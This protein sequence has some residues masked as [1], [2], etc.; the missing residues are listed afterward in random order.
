[1]ASSSTRRRGLGGSCRVLLR[2]QGMTGVGRPPPRLAHLRL[3]V[4]LAPHHASAGANRLHRRPRGSGAEGAP[5][6]CTRRATADSG[7]TGAGRRPSGARAPHILHP[8]AAAGQEGGR[9][10][11]EQT[12][13][14]KPAR[15]PGAASQRGALVHGAGRG[16]TQRG[17]PCDD[18]KSSPLPPAVQ[19]LGAPC[20]EWPSPGT[21]SHGTARGVRGRPKATE[22]CAVVLRRPRA[23]GAGAG[24]SARPALRIARRRWGGGRSSPAP[25]SDGL[26]RRVG[27]CH[28]LQLGIQKTN[29]GRGHVAFRKRAGRHA[30]RSM[31]TVR[32]PPC[33][34]SARLPSGRSFLPG[35]RNGRK[36]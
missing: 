16:R 19:W 6:P 24:R 23:V 3:R 17:V 35:P 18:A 29:T 7:P 32:Q 14:G 27:R 1:M 13:A 8:R 25:N 28:P 33:E 2:K 11:A 15:R 36:G 26:V 10:C 4:N 9:P 12:G 20:S 21:A 30:P 22:G 5:R 34:A 31:C